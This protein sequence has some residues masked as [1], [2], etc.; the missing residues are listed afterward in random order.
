MTEGVLPGLQPAPGP[1]LVS[2]PMAFGDA[3]VLPE[4]ASAPG[5]AG[6]SRPMMGGE[7]SVHATGDPGRAALEAVL[8]RIE[9]WASRLTRFDPSSELMRL[10]ATSSERV[11]I[12]PT[13]TAV[14]DWAR[15]AEG[16]SDGLVDV[17]ML[18][19]RLA[20]EAGT[21]AAS[22]VSASRRWSIDRGPRASV[23]RRQPGVRFDLDGV[24]KGWLA[25]RALA[26]T[27][28]RSALVDADGDIALRLAPGDRWGIAVADPREDGAL[29]G[30]LQFAAEQAA[31]RLGVATSGTSVHRWAHAAGETHHLID[32]RT[33]RPAA[34]DVVQATVVAGT[35]REAEVLAKTAVIAGSD[36][37][38]HILDRPG[39]LGV[40]LLTTRGEI[41]ATPEILQWLA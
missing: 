25:D 15:G 20:A 3:V 16:M 40:L 19:A 1:A 29:L 18:D 2:R 17:A 12:G 11:R 35:A 5:P 38:F 23:V 36:R 10:N 31:R 9:A 14:L 28:G 8:D 21:D 22:P 4:L 27:P 24:A 32:P 39:V 26:I 13:L 6:A 7:V 37:A 30:V 33:W 34:T 41:R